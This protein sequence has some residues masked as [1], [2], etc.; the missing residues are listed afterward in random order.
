MK[1][2]YSPVHLDHDP[3]VQFEAGH[4]LPAV[5]IPVRV[6]K[7]RVALEARRIGPI[8]PPTP[9]DDATILAVHDAGLVGLLAE[10]W[11]EWTK[12]YGKDAAVAIPS[13]W[14]APGLHVRHHDGGRKD[15]I[16]SRLGRYA[17]SSDAPIARG[18]WAA[19][20]GQAQ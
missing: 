14:P 18:T 15:D 20:R 1:T 2:F 5:E 3:Q 9:F 4:L 19:A 6:E 13:A 16:E 8:V 12:R 7:V 11:D 17:F 10:A